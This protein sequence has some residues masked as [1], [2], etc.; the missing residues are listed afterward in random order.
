MFIRSGTPGFDL[1]AAPVGHTTMGGLR[2]LYA[3]SVC[4]GLGAWSKANGLILNETKTKCVIFHAPG[5]STTLPDNIVLG[6]YKINITSSIKTLG[7]IFTAQ[8]SWNEHVSH[9]CSKVRKVVGVLN[10][11]RSSLPFKVKRLIYHAL[12]HS[13]LSYCFLIWGSTTAQNI[14]MLEILQKKAIRAIANVSF[15]EHTQELF[16]QNRIIRVR[17]IYKFKTLL[18][19]RNA[20]LGRLDSF[21][22]LATLQE[23][24]STYSYRHQAPWQIPFSC[25]NYGCQR[26]KH[27]LPS[28]LNYFNQ[29]NVDVLSLNK[30]K[31][32]DLFL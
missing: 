9:V 29:Q 13:H 18:S 16:Q 23:S 17:D 12:F 1:C 10:R 11:N 28:L 27:T 31:I 14:Q 22:T 30:T 4:Y 3:S 8:M 20:M 21:L 26:L 5:S 19:Y 6:P 15:F 24:R 7:V 2:D 25:T 32:L